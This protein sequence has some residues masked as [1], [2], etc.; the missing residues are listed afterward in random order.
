MTL[1]ISWHTPNRIVLERF[2]GD[3]TYDD[4]RQADRG[5]RELIGAG[6]APVHILV[7]LRDVARF[8][9]NI[10]KISQQVEHRNHPDLGWAVIISNHGMI[11]FIVRLVTEFAGNRIRMFTTMD[12]ALDFLLAM[13]D[14]LT[15]LLSVEEVMLK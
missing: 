8:P 7:D 11:Q 1:H 10:L 3:V 2:S 15:E 13:D 12:E 5:G 9:T 4:I 6:D 14:G